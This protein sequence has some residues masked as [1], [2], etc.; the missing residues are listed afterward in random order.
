M[1]TRVI[2]HDFEFDALVALLRERKRPFTVQITAG[3]NRSVEQNRTQRLWLKEAA[4]QLDSGYT[5]ENLRGFCKL[6]FGVPILRR[7]S[8]Q[9]RAGYDR[10]IKPHSYEEKLL[11]MQEPFDFGVTRLM[12][13]KQKTEYLDAVCAHFVGQGVVLTIP[14]ERGRAA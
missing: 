9:F 14:E 8:E 7:D 2:R 10:I 4:E 1:T 13:T 11:M 3:A 5:A 12:T 6:H